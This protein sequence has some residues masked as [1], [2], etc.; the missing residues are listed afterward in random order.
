MDAAQDA[1]ALAVDQ[2][3]LLLGVAASEHEDQAFALTIE[4]V[5][6]DVGEGIPNSEHPG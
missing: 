1:V 2:P 6:C 5:D 4:G 3:A